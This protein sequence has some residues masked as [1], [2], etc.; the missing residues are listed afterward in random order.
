[1][2][3]KPFKALTFDVVG[4]LIDFETGVL[5]AFRRIGGP[6]A[7]GLSDDEIF[8]PFLEARNVH[9]GR[10]FDVM[11]DVYRYVAKKLSLA[12]SVADAR[13]FQLA[14]LEWPAFSDSAEALARLRRHFRLVATTN[15]DRVTLA[16]YCHTLGNPFDELICY[17]DTGCAKP[18]PKFFSFTLGR[19]SGRGIRQSEILHV[20]QSQYHDIGVAKAEGF[21]TCWIERRMALEGYGAT[22]VPAVKTTPDFHFSCLRDLADAVDAELG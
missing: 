11:A 16:A 20:A 2:T 7:Q 13:E 8:Q 1:M 17:D 14:L 9:Y 18:D 21:R 15:A 12:N 4:T 22:P 10:N 5:N 19:Q 6:A 3:F